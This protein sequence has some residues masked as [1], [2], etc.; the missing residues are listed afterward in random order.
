MTNSP[1]RLISSAAALLV[2]LT[3]SCPA[4]AQEILN[5]PQGKGH[6]I[7]FISGMAGPKHDKAL[8]EAVADLGYVVVVY[9]GRT[10][11]EGQGQAIRSALENARQL[12]NAL[13]G[14]AALMGVSLGGGFALAYGVRWPD[15]VAVDI[16]WYPATGFVLRIPTF[17]SRIRVPVLMFA[18]ESDNYQNCCLITTARS[19]ASD[20]AVLKAPFELVTYPGAQHDFIEGGSNFN[21]TAY[22]NTVERAAAKLKTAFGD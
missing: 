19:L 6:V 17:A 18:G 22:N 20:A 5:P 13:P 3:L 8:A 7:V 12:P 21:P 2:T 15:L 14:K 4:R 16:V 1:F 10:M 11:D 9:D